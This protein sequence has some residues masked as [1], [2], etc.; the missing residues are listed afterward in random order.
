MSNPEVQD[1]FNR[2][3]DD[4]VLNHRG[5]SEMKYKAI[6]A[7]R[8]CRTGILGGHIDE[9][10][11]CGHINISYNSCRNR[12]CPKCQT[13][14]KEKWIDRMR[15]NLINVPYFHVVF[16]IPEELNMVAYYNQEVVYKILFDAAA[17]TLKELSADSKYLGAEIGF[18]S[19][20]HSWGQNLLLH[21]HNHVLVPAGGI[22]ADGQL[23][24]SAKNFFI[25]VKVLSKKFRGKFLHK[26]KRAF[27]KLEF[28]GKYEKLYKNSEFHRLIDSC[29]RKQW[30]VYCKETFSGPEAVIEYL[31]RYTHKI[32]I[33][34]SRILDIENGK[35]TFKWR[36]YRDNKE[37]IMTIS[38]EE[39]IRRFLMH[40]LPKRF[41]K[42]RHYG[43][44]SNRNRK[45]KLKA[46]Q[47][48]TGCSDIKAKF[49]DLNPVEIIL[50]ITGRDVTKCPCCKIGTMISKIFKHIKDISPS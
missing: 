3:I 23:K 19:I 13:F 41:I 32:A 15:E 44:M 35:V 39:F 28:K 48:L 16:T 47:K 37:K 12:N 20:L 26:L 42:I 2:Y 50:K 31:G 36:D 8:S 9:C 5:L 34:N 10:N 46:C 38:A 40:I 17:E 33:S 49:K 6:S 11:A 21:P 29:Y 1:I 24:I 18:T 45:T 4:Y 14:A 25:P 43:I 22:G 27:S 30:V 7:I